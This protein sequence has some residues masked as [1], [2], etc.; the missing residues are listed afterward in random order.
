LTR[1]DDQTPH[2]RRSRVTI[3]DVARQA[4]VSV[5]T[6]SVVLN[7]RPTAIPVG[8]ETRQRVLAAGAALDYRPNP[9]ARSL[10][11]GRSH[12]LGLMVTTITDPFTG[13]VVQ[14]MDAVARERGY[15][16]LL[17][18]SGMGLSTEGQPAPGEAPGLRFVDGALLLGFQL[19]G[20]APFPGVAAQHRGLVTAIPNHPDLPSFA[21]D[22][23]VRAGAHLALQH[24]RD[25]GHRRIGMILDP[26]HLRMRERR[27][28]FDE[29][30]REANL[31]PTPGAIGITE[32]TYFEGGKL[33]TEHLLAQP[34]P[35]TAI[36]AANDQLAV[37]AL[38]AAWRRGRRIPDDLSIV[39]FD[40]LPV[41]Q[42]LT[43]PLT[44]VRQPIAE[45]GRTAIATLID[46][47]E[48]KRPPT[49]LADLV[50][51][52]ELVIRDSSSPPRGP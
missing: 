12:T 19:R 2:S 24:L 28:A 42:Y 35:P 49:L 7:G 41:A 4:G 47:L 48:A 32:A 40:D 14:A 43:P 5:T 23:S 20:L 34:Q 33:A 36:L 26:R 18:L 31:P 11:T 46:L 30:M 17:M 52:P 38:H 37:G 10:R 50:L 8:E 45:L 3:K 22:V 15:R 25:L 27:A 6:A 9:F 16:T 1:S 51:Q 21:V 44:T 29:F 39:G 13:E